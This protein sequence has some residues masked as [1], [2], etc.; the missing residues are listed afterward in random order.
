MGIALTLTAPGIPMLFQGQE[1]LQDGWFQ[2]TEPMPW[3]N[4]DEH[5]G[6]GAANR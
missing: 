4:K 6:I 1:L 5:G 3:E 2:D